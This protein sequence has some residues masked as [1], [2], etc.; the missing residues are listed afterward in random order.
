M[1]SVFLYG[2]FNHQ[3]VV[4]GLMIEHPNEKGK[5]N[6]PVFRSQHFSCPSFK[7]VIKPVMKEPTPFV[8]ESWVVPI[9][10][11]FIPSL[12]LKIFA[13][14][15]NV[16][17]KTQIN[18]E[19][20]YFFKSEVNNSLHQANLFSGCPRRRMC[21][22]IEKKTETRQFKYDLLLMGKTP[23]KEVK[24]KVWIFFLSVYSRLECASKPVRS[25]ICCP[26]GSSYEPKRLPRRK[27]TVKQKQI[28]F[29]DLPK[30][31]Q[32]LTWNEWWLWK[33]FTVKTVFFLTRITTG[34]GSSTF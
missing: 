11:R 23:F 33:R 15:K 34:V 32:L 18:R 14:N 10:G 16:N 25:S 27:V 26:S 3:T 29:Y 22:N 2:D 19:F 28:A 9:L 6:V 24:K 1:F 20:G 17:V 12:W 30:D 5:R 7:S 8:T 13:W 4:C 21:F 31:L